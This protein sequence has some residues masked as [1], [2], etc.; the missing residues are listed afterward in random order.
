MSRMSV[1]DKVGQLFLV[2]FSGADVNHGS[3]VLQ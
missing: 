1:E 2:P 3:E